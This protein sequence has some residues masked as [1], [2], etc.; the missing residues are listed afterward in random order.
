MLGI[1]CLVLVGRALRLCRRPPTG[2]ASRLAL[3]TL[4]WAAHIAMMIALY[5][6]VSYLTRC[7]LVDMD[8]AAGAARRC[9]QL[10]IDTA[11]DG[12]RARPRHR[13]SFPLEMIF[14]GGIAAGFVWGAYLTICCLFGLHCDQAFASMGIPGFQ[15]FP[16][17]E[18]RALQA[19][20]LSDRLAEDAAALVVAPRQEHGR[21]A[22]VPEGPAIVPRAAAAAHADRG[23]D[24]D[25]RGRRETAR[26][27]RR[28]A[29]WRA[30]EAVGGAGW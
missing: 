15:E 29:S 26:S 16:A 6:A 8:L 21:R 19:H 27:A 25:S 13:R 14:L 11:G 10:Q 17:P 3:G 18:D 4:H 7:E 12:A 5:Y 22:A 24:R 28:C 30:F 2:G 23:A 20:D 9:R 1:L